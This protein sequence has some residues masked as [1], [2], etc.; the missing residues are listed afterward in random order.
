MK[1]AF[2]MKQK[3]F[4]SIL[5]ALLLKQLKRIFLR[6][7]LVKRCVMHSKSDEIKKNMSHDK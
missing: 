7:T 2:N 6:K 5:K 4:F 1:R 3:G